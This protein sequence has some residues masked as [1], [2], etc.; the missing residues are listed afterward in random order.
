[1]D[2]RVLLD[3]RT[4]LAEEEKDLLRAVCAAREEGGEV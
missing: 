2:G 1:M 4:V 3:P